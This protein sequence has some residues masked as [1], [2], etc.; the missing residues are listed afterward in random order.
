MGIWRDQ[1]VWCVCVCVFVV[2]VRW[3]FGGI[4]VCVCGVRVCVCEVCD[5]CV[6]WVFGGIKRAPMRR[7]EAAVRESQVRESVCV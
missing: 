5:V 6:R 3:V 7:Q 1:G 4:K 2:C